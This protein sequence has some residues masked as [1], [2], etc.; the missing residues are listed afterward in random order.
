M[1]KDRVEAVLSAA[2]SQGSA[3]QTT[4]LSQEQENIFFHRSQDVMERR[5]NL[6]PTTN[7][8][9]IRLESSNSDV[10]EES[11]SPK[12][13]S[14]LM[15]GL[16]FASVIL[17]ELVQLAR[18]FTLNSSEQFAVVTAMFVSSQAYLYALPATIL[19]LSAV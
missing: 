5:I 1:S 17:T 13:F 6:S 19:G 7:R 8:M 12:T 15:I 4:L 14:L 3:F 9:S 10:S 16:P 18:L 2:L 11:S